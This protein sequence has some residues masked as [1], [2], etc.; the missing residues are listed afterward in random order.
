VNLEAIV[1]T[2]SH[3]EAI[4]HTVQ[5][6]HEWLRDVAADLGIANRRH[7]YLALRGTLHAVRDFLPID[8]SAHLSAQLPMLIRGIYFEGWDPA[9]TP[10]GATEHRT[11]EDFLR[12]I[13]TALDRAVWDEEEGITAEQ[14]ARSAL[15]V[16]SDRISI[17]E[18]EQIRRVMPEAVRDLWPE[19]AVQ[20]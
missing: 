10:T 16:L 9:K 18:A 19:L 15:I 12:S 14:A 8:E 7:A 5:Q 17:G 13:E 20:R 3:V 2:A 1:M 11:R 6:T 4:D